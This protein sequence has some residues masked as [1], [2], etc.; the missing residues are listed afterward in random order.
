MDCPSL[1]YNITQVDS[2]LEYGSCIVSSALCAFD[3][4]SV[5]RGSLSLLYKFQANS[6][7]RGRMPGYLYVKGDIN[8]ACGILTSMLQCIL[9][10]L[11][12][13]PLSVSFC[14]E[15]CHHVCYSIY[16]RRR[17]ISQYQ[18]SR[19]LHLRSIP[20]RKREVL[21]HTISY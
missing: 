21:V 5:R 2:L 20:D 4:E 6:R 10:H 17:I 12:H 9:H 1:S 15:L 3:R 16:R 8:L 11:H 14:A 7:S 13:F 19:R 18:P